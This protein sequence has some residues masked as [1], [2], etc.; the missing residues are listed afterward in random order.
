M[1]LIIDKATERWPHDTSTEVYSF[2]SEIERRG[3]GCGTWNRAC[4]QVEIGF[5]SFDQL[6]AVI[7]VCTGD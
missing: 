6:E 1:K 5:V 4:N 3:G 7:A 2:I